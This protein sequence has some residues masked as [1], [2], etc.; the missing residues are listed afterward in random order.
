MYGEIKM[1]PKLFWFGSFQTS[2]SV[3]HADLV[4]AWFE[5][6][7]GCYRV[8]LSL[9]C[10]PYLHGAFPS[11]SAG[12]RG[13]LGRPKLVLYY[14]PALRDLKCACSAYSPTAPTIWCLLWSLSMQARPILHSRIHGKPPEYEPLFTAFFSP[15]S[16]PTDSSPL[17]SFRC[18][19]LAE[20]LLCSL[21]SL[22]VSELHWRHFS[23]MW[24]Y[25][26]PFSQGS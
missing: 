23:Q 25:E 16:S 26:F 1:L 18:W 2:H 24:S 6:V 14:P 12:Y 20:T 17:N 22:Q 3:S 11:V 15:V 9:G 19:P 4:K 7:Y 13:M 5:D 21:L 10:V 8:G